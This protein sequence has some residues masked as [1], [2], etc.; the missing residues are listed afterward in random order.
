MNNKFN[1]NTLIS[2]NKYKVRG[3]HECKMVSKYFCNFK[4]RHERMMYIKHKGF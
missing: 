2:F 1:K 4:N 3:K